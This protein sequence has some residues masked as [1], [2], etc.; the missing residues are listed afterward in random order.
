[1]CWHLVSSFLYLRQWDHDLEKV[2]DLKRADINIGLSNERPKCSNNA[3]FPCIPIR[4]ITIMKKWPILGYSQCF[5]SLPVSKI[6]HMRRVSSQTDFVRLK[7][8]RQE[9]WLGNISDFNI[10]GISPTIDQGC[11]YCDRYDPGHN[12]WNPPRFIWC[13]ADSFSPYFLVPS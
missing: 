3:T 5:Q 9:D 7:V 11:C 8:N 2:L 1:M 12:R 13:R 4:P 10:K 6:N